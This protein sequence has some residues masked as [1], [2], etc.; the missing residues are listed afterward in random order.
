MPS[1]EGC[2]RAQGRKSDR[3]YALL[4][5]ICDELNPDGFSKAEVREEFGTASSENPDLPHSEAYIENDFAFLEQHGL[6]QS[7][8]D[9]KFRVT[10]TGMSAAAEES[11]EEDEEGAD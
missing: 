1:F 10:E 2:E 6:I 7:V 5:R 4:K 9:K 11:P 8:D 3:A